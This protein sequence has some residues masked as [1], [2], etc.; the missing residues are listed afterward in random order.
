MAY[1]PSYT[2]SDLPL[3]AQDWIGHM[4]VEGIVYAGLIVLVLVAGFVMAKVTRIF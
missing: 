1:T 3:I 4:G 2:G